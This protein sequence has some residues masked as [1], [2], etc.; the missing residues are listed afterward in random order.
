MTGTT[1]CCESVSS[2]AL[3]GWD[4]TVDKCKHSVDK[5][6][7]FRGMASSNDE[8]APAGQAATDASASGSS[9][10]VTSV[11]NTQ[12]PAEME[13]DNHPFYFESDHVALKGTSLY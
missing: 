11:Y 9:Q 2:V 5:L 3:R 10:D 7:D 6:P 1:E 12:S 8:V 13:E 4:T